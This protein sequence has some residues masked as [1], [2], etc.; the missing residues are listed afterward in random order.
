[1][2]KCVD[3]PTG[4]G[5]GVSAE[6]SSG[7]IFLLKELFREAKGLQRVVNRNDLHCVKCT[8]VWYV[9]FSILGN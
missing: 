2:G 7:Q 4:K 8:L 3:E 1:M 5:K 6:M 9:P